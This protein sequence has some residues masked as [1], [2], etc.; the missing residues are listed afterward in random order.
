MQLFVSCV[1]VQK[2]WMGHFVEY[3]CGVHLPM[4]AWC[5]FTAGAS[6]D[7][8]VSVRAHCQWRAPMTHVC[9]PLWA[10][11]A[12]TVDLL[13]KSRRHAV[14]TLSAGFVCIPTLSYMCLDAAFTLLANSSMHLSLKMATAMPTEGCLLCSHHRRNFIRVVLAIGTSIILPM[15]AVKPLHICWYILS[16]PPSNRA[17]QKLSFRKPEVHA[18]KRPP[19]SSNTKKYLPNIPFFVSQDKLLGGYLRSTPHPVTV[20]NAVINEGL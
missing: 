3:S 1:P 20:I 4:S 19:E 13:P 16:M 10:A 11:A 2:K 6:T 14:M 17:P 18:K 9:L 8:C 15:H 7:I 5:I 12:R